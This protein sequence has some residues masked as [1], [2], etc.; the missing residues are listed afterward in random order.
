MVVILFYIYMEKKFRYWK[1]QGVESQTKLEF[2]TGTIAALG[3]SFHENVINTYKRHGRIFGTC[4]PSYDLWISKPELIKHIL[5]KDF[6]TFRIRTKIDFGDPIVNKM[7]SF[8]ND[9]DWKRV[10]NLM[11]PTFTSSRMRK[12]ANLVKQCAESLAKRFNENAEKGKNFDCKELTSTFTI[13]V[14]ASTA[15]ATKLNAQENE[16][17]EFVKNAR[18]VSNRN[19]SKLTLL[20]FLIA[21]K[22]IGYLKLEFFP[23][24]LLEYF[25]NVVLKILEERKQKKVKGNDFLQLMMDAQE[26]ILENTAEDL[27]EVESEISNNKLQPKHKTMSLDEIVAQSILFIIAGHDTTTNALSFFCYEMALNPECQEKLLKEIDETWETHGD[28]DFDIVN[29]MT[30]LDAA[31]NETLRVHNP[32]VMLARMAS[33]DYKLA[34][35][36]ITIKKGTNIV[37]PTY[38]MHHDPEYFPEPE[39]FKPERFLPENKESIIPYTFLPFGD[40]PRNCIGMRFVTMVMKICL[41]Y[42]LRDVK[43]VATEETRKPLKYYFGQNLQVKDIIL[44]AEKRTRFH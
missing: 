30:Y 41:V 21:P 15:F 5:V 17:N 38:G 34:D 42:M 16:N 24:K 20:G 29:K 18:M 25:Q 11:S 1:E 23:R 44:K 7:L 26:G 33:E 13:D 22:L 36:G 19:I 32:G 28:V 2:L 40:G 9:E 39:R 14:T 4:M 10:R 35:T 37:I 3:M 8:I 27:K 6:P 12:M 43:L 31:L